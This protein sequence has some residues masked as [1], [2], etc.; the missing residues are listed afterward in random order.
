MFCSWEVFD[1]VDIE[2]LG[3]RM[4]IIA[5]PDDVIALFR[6]WIQERLYFFSI[7]GENSYLDDIARLR[8]RAST[9]CTLFD[10]QFYHLLMIV[11]I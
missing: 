9:L 1:E 3:K 11:I 5:L 6:V 2:L 4:R 7:N 8:F 10:P